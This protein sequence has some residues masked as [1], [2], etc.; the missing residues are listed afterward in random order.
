MNNPLT[1]YK[2]EHSIKKMS[3]LLG[4]RVISTNPPMCD[5]CKND[6]AGTNCVKLIVANGHICIAK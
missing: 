5:T 4:G 6:A 1:V 3:D 2:M